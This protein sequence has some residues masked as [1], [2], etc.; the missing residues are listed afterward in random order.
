[1]V[2]DFGCGI[3][4]LTCG[5]SALVLAATTY[6]EDYESTI[7]TGHEMRLVLFAQK[8]P[9]VNLASIAT[10]RASSMYLHR[11]VALFASSKN[12]LQNRPTR[13]S[14]VAE[15]SPLHFGGPLLP[16]PCLIPVALSSGTGVSGSYQS[17]W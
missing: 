16:K 3:K 6:R 5:Y 10:L 12:V 9:A 13:N 15:K 11:S 17:R 1:M 7:A 4:L 14:A 2:V 8:I